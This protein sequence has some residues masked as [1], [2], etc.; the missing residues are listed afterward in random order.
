[1]Q[2]GCV[3]LRERRSHPAGSMAG[4]KPFYF[5]HAHGASNIICWSPVGAYGRIESRCGLRAASWAGDKAHDPLILWRQQC[6]VFIVRGILRP[7]FRATES[8]VRPRTPGHRAST[9]CRSHV[10]FKFGTNVMR[11]IFYA[12][13]SSEIFRISINVGSLSSHSSSVAV[14]ERRRDETDLGVFDRQEVKFPSGKRV[15]PG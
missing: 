13:N 14:N 15:A 7:I 11:W 6:R 1:M 5:P 10:L 4:D 12:H 2:R 9:M 3:S 8:L